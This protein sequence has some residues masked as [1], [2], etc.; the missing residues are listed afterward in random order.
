MDVPAK[1]RGLKNRDAGDAKNPAFLAE[2][3]A[4]VK[5]RNAMELRE[6]E[7][8]RERAK[9]GPGQWFQ[10]EHPFSGGKK[11][12]FPVPSHR[13]PSHRHPDGIAVRNAGKH[14]NNPYIIRA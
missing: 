9:N 5:K 7:R 10:P 4:G 11:R 2:G 3:G 1:P 13:H 8:E 6:R 12:S 14:T